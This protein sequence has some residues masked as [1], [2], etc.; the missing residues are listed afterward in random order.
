[1]PQATRGGRDKQSLI[2]TT[3]KQLKN[4]PN[5]ASGDSTFTLDGR[6]LYQVTIV[7]MITAAEENSTNLQYTIEDGTDSI[8]VK[9]WIDAEAS[10]T[11]AERRAQWRENVIVRVIGQLREF[12][13]NKN[14]VAYD[15]CPI[16]DFNEYSFHFIDVVHTHL[17]HT[18]GVCS[19]QHIS[20]AHLA[21]T[22]ACSREL[23]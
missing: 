19:R 10:E 22:S 3:I 4:A 15:I 13:G 8:M 23:F 6:E 17:R 11:F 18:R 9:M 5:D 12:N 21:S 20:P 14:L 16:T 1:M 2:P 7:G